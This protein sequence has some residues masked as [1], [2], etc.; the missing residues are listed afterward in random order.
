MRSKLSCYQL[1]IDCYR[2]KQLRK[3]HGNYK[4]KTYGKHTK[5][6]EKRISL[7]SSNHK[8]REQEKKEQGKQ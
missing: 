5:R 6:K 1:K 3:P 7:K 8:A 2:Y 4:A